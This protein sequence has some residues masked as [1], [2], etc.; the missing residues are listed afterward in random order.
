M[1]WLEF[2]RN[3]TQWQQQIIIPHLCNRVWD[4][5][6]EACELSGLAGGPVAV[7]W[8]PPRREMINPAQEAE[9][10]KLMIRN[11]MT[12]LSETIRQLG[13]DPEEVFDE[14]KDDLEA[15][16]KRGLIFDCDPRRRNA[17]GAPVDAKT[18][19]PDTAA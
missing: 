18:E 4:W 12:T 7:R 16:D 19:K 6:V 5:F 1:G 8:T 14:M 13:R 9:A 10:M 17:V 2:Q 11:G 15:L 3:V